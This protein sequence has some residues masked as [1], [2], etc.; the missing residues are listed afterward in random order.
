M[1]SVPGLSLA[2][3]GNLKISEV[4]VEFFGRTIWDKIKEKFG[5]Y[6]NQN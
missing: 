6:E 3:S 4:K 1:I 5:V 2:N